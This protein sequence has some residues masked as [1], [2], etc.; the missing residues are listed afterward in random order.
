M[1]KTVVPKGGVGGEGGDG[2]EWVTVMERKM[3]HLVKFDDLR[4]SVT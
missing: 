1:T 2:G 4:S 3:R